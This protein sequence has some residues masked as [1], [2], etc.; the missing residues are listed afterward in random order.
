MKSTPQTKTE[1][2]NLRLS[3]TV[4]NILER[5]AGFKGKTVS[6]FI[7]HS[8]LTQDEKTVQRHAVM[9]LSNENSISFCEALAAPVQFNNKLIATLEEHAKRVISK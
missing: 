5:A 4:K 6:N 8:A 3:H 7:L 2:I 9:A 1:R